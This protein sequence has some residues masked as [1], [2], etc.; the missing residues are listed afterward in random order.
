MTYPPGH[1]ESGEYLMQLWREYL[2]QYAD[3]EGDADGQTIVAAYHT[4]K[5]LTAFS[6]I[7]DR[8][9]HYKELID[10]RISLFEEGSKRADIFADRL[11]NATFSIYNSLNTL[12]HQ[13]T[14]RSAEASAEASALIRKV[15]EQVH[16]S[17]ESTET[18]SRPAVALR[19]CFPLLGL[20]AITLDQY[21]K[22]TGAIRHVEQRY[23][24]CAKAAS[25]DQEHLLNALYRIVEMFQI[26][27]LTTD[28]NLK[29]RI[30]Q[31]A[32]RFKEEDQESDLRLKLCNGFCRLFELAHL[33]AS[34]VN[35]IV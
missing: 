17:I 13:L 12:S 23:A 18:A 29:D 24:T 26:V 34:Q 20:I 19:A 27:A 31:I 28:A 8:N 11:V 10:A 14:E 7:L 25:S 15:D 32:V 1:G 35:A 33:I 6:R 4:V 22:M 2:E 9:S 3:N 30:N 5:V 16:K 21:Q